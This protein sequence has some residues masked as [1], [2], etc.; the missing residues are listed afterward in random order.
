MNAGAEPG[1]C[2]RFGVVYDGLQQKVDGEWAFLRDLEDGVE[3]AL[4]GVDCLV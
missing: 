3:V 1:V 2:L 4:P